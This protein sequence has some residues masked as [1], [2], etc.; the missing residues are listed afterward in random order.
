MWL[1]DTVLESTSR[2]SGLLMEYICLL[3]NPAVCYFC[4]DSFKNDFVFPQHIHN[5]KS[6][7]RDLDRC[8][9]DDFGSEIL[10]L[11]V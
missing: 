3:R 8:G 5:I 1:I 6:E 2:Q 11:W 10:F 4:I 7:G 9:K